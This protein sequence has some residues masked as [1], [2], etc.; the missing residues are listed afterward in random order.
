MRTRAGAR[1][2]SGA[3]PPGDTVSRLYIDGSWRDAHRARRILNPFDASVIATVAEGDADDAADAVVAARRAF[4][5]GPWRSTSAT[6][7]GRLLGLIADA[8]EADIDAFARLETLDTGKTLEESR[9]DNA[10]VVAVFRYYAGL[11]DKAAGEV[12]DTGV[13]RTRSVVVREPVGVCVQISPWNYPLL[14]ASWKLAPAL[15]AGCTV[16]VKPSELT[17]LTT[18]RLFEV[19]DDL[20]LPPGVANLVLG[21]GADVGAPLVVDPRVDM[22]SFTGGLETGRGVMADAAATVKKVALELGGKNPNI[23]FADADLDAALDYALLAAFLHSGQVCSAGAR[24]LV[25]DAIHDEF[26]GKL[27][28]RAGRIRLGDG[29]D[30]LTESGPLVS[31]EHREKV[32]RHVARALE[33]G[34]ELALGGERPR[35]PALA[36]G[37]F[38]A[39]T[40]LTGC[41]QGMRI[42][43]E[44]V[45][46]PVLSVERFSTEEEVVARTNDTI[47]G[48][49]GAVWTSD[50][51][52]A[53]RVA[54][55][56]RLG[57]VWIN[58]FHP[59]APQAEW[60]GFKQS[61][62]GREL[63][64]Q[65]LEEYTEAK[66]VY[67]N[68]APKP[69]G[70]FKG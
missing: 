59:Y 10:D 16:V 50:A 24:L 64:R 57:T 36:D 15:A 19:L 62:V 23:V 47:Y 69:S 63:G 8:I 32:E 27:V 9:L 43:Q 38:Y 42:V 60:G 56:L 52:R 14:Q 30:E 1:S 6:H 65:G 51:G 26:V 44:E 67:T 53:E 41:R 40:I 54:A 7:R 49:A 37:F 18:I 25:E 39:P 31:A 70:W 68:L 4:D 20:D 11:A 5:H 55:A 29:M 46:G 35:D 58:D 45:F 22:V 34:A 28:E 66:H 21:A 13:P 48:L 3:L 61:G 33:E 17:P 2:G 12:V